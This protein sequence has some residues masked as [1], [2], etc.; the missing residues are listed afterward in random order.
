MFVFD[1]CSPQSPRIYINE[2]KTGMESGNEKQGDGMNSV[3]VC[4]R[5]TSYLLFNEIYIY[6]P[7]C[8]IDVPLIRVIN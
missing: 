6:P 8:Y 5:I 3:I 4:V 1:P 2:G 7:Q